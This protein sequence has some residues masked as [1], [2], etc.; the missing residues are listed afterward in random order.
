M[1]AVTV[2]TG[3][4]FLGANVMPMWLGALMES[5]A[6]DLEQAG[7]I[8]SAEL[9]AGAVACLFIA[10]LAG[11]I[12]R[13][14]LAMIACACAAAGYAL[15]ALAGSYATLTLIRMATGFFCG[16]VL[17]A[18]NAA[19]AGA[20]DP[21]RV[22]AAVG[23]F[24]GAAASV[25]IVM[26]GYASGSGG[27]PGIFLLLTGVVLISIPVFRWLTEG[28]A[29]PQV[30]ASATA[31]LSSKPLL[32][33]AAVLLLSISGQGLWAF[34]ER[35]GDSIGLETEQIGWWISVS[36]LSGLTSAAFAAWLGTRL[37]RTLPITLAIV[38]SGT[39]QWILVNADTQTAYVIAL[40]GWGL[41]LNFWFPFVMGLL[42]ELDRGGRWTVVSGA[43]AM[44]GIAI[45]PWVAGQLLEQ[46]PDHGLA[47]LLVGCAVA[48]L[49]LLLPVSIAFDRLA[50]RG[51]EFDPAVAGV[52]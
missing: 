31:R 41:A 49:L 10:P 12:S 26:V 22:Y 29:T 8:G 40:F 17:A 23:F 33:L 36:S 2:A 5:L 50:G 44:F 34:T 20:R 21:D 13:R 18:G 19:G 52:D 9:L 25:L 38:L 51:S 4:G 15:S 47:T 6:L 37:G 24:A 32:T 35:I 28:V 7:R 30:A 14:R 48:A 16:I 45:G 27:V 11:R 1:F 46:S 43:V 42:A 3:I 39:S